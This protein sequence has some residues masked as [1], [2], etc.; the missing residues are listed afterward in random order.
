MNDRRPWPPQ[1]A[2]VRLECGPGRASQDANRL[3][4]RRRE[5][6]AAMIAT[7]HKLRDVPGDMPVLFQ[8]A[9][10]PQAPIT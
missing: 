10:N 2:V 6:M 3:A 1:T 8:D 5:P 9:P 7:V 4:G